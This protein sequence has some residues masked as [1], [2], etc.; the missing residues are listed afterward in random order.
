MYNN[1]PALLTRSVLSPVMHIMLFILKIC[2]QPCFLLYLLSLNRFEGRNE[3]A[4]VLAISQ[5]RAGAE[6]SGQHRPYDLNQAESDLMGRS[7]CIFFVS[8]HAYCLVLLKA[9]AQS[10]SFI[11][12]FVLYQSFG[13]AIKAISWAFEN[14]W[15]LQEDFMSLMFC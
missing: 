7:F 2:I 10:G 5:K 9:Y 4:S 12:C 1:R 3:T 14:G 11:F 13:N 15:N 8:I 6:F